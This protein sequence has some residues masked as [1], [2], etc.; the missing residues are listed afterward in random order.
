MSAD[1]EGAA[2][3]DVQAEVAVLAACFHSPVASERASKILSGRDFFRPVHED[4]FESIAGLRR[5]GTPVD[6]VTLGDKLRGLDQPQNVEGA[7]RL[8]P[9]LLT[10]PV[11][12]EDV[13]RSEEHTS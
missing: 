12:P 3:H 2:P 10:N 11:L 4:V 1:F 9:D 6:H 8:L 5:A 7:M 13:A